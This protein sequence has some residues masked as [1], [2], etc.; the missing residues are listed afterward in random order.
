M[1]LYEFVDKL[2][3]MGDMEAPKT[4][5][6]K[7]TLNESYGDTIET[8]KY[9][10]RGYNPSNGSIDPNELY[11]VVKG[12][13]QRYHLT[14]LLKLIRRM[15]RQ[16]YD[17][18][19]SEEGK[20]EVLDR[21]LKELTQ[22]DAEDIRD[23][24]AYFLSEVYDEEV[25][26]EG[27]LGGLA[28]AA[29]GGLAG[30]S[31]GHP[32]LGAIGGGLAG[33]AIQNALFDEDLDEAL[34]DIVS[35]DVDFNIDDGEDFNEIKN[36]LKDKFNIDVV[37]Y[38]P[39][40]LYDNITLQGSKENLVKYLSTDYGGYDEDDPDIE[41]VEE[42]FPELLDESLNE[43][44]FS[45]NELG[46]YIRKYLNPELSLANVEVYNSGNHAEVQVQLEPE[47]YNNDG[48]GYT[49]NFVPKE[50]SVEDFFDYVVQSLNNVSLE[51][52]LNEDIYDGE[53]PTVYVN[54]KKIIK[55]NREEDWESSDYFDDL[56][57]YGPFLP[58]EKYIVG[59]EDE[60]GNTMSYKELC[61]YLLADEDNVCILKYKKGTEEVTES[62]LGVIKE[63]LVGIYEDKILDMFNNLGIEVLDSYHDRFYNDLAD[64]G[65]GASKN[66]D[67]FVVEISES[68]KESKLSQPYTD[69]KEFKY[70]ESHDIHCDIDNSTKNDGAVAFVFYTEIDGKLTD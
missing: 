23:L 6:S 56:D 52:G 11:I 48:Y 3:E 37:R 46:E 69:M 58:K 70:L 43:A 51:E 7:K 15:G 40:G 30:N 64:M 32:V 5:R 26:D 22:P 66:V 10:I 16:W 35:V 54:N 50:T 14:D 62:G 39:D 24:I 41:W 53:G 12:T 13:Y 17:F 36:Y 33:S 38:D 42:F 34:D 29:I 8:N 27:I 60:N 67:C 49:F 19:V 57:Y 20:N 25:L 47:I 63:S 65:T 2:Y 28:G 44:L 68:D 31:L 9:K 61:D 59:I 1:K 21:L 18:E 4:I 45:E 55:I